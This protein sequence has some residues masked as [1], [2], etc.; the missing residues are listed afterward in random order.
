MKKLAIILIGAI[1]VVGGGFGIYSVTKGSG[2][3]DD[4]NTSS[5]SSN[6]FSPVANSKLSFEAT[7]TTVSKGKTTVAVMESDA[8]TGAVRY[9]ADE[10]DGSLAMIYTKDAYYTCQD[11]GGCFKFVLGKGQGASFDPKA[12]QYSESSLETFKQ[13]SQKLATEDCKTG[14]CDVWQVANTDGTSTKIYIDNA[15]K[16]VVKVSGQSG[17]ATSTIEYDYKE[18]SVE[19]PKDAKEL[20]GINSTQP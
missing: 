1:V 3:K 8:K 17:G 10:N 2:D 18:V 5:N 9:S 6:T 11:E 19:V 16:R 4:S 12:Y 20:P 13:S 15:T 14:K 7:I